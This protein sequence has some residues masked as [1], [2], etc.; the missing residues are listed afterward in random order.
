MADTGTYVIIG[1]GV[2]VTAFLI[3]LATRQT[4]Q[5]IQPTNPNPVQRDA[6]ESV[7][8]GAIRGFASFFQGSGSEGQSAL[9]P[10]PPSNTN[11][12]PNTGSSTYP[13]TGGWSFQGGNNIN[14]WQPW[15]GS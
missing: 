15:E 9:P 2:V 4:Q 5:M 6:L 10:R 12:G 14:N 13:S 8:S 3:H 11:P 7:V 1:G